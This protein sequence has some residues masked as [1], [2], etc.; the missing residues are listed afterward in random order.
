[1]K[2]LDKNKVSDFAFIS[3]IREAS[4]SPKPGLV[5][6]YNSG[7]HRDMDFNTFIKSSFAIKNYFG[8][9]FSLGYEKDLKEEDRLLKLREL[10]KNCEDDMYKATNNVNT[11]KG[12]IF[13]LGLLSF[14][15]GILE[16]EN[17]NYNI[18]KIIEK[19]ESICSGISS[20]LKV[21][22]PKTYGEKLYSK[23]GFKG[24]RGE[25]EEGFKKANTI[26]IKNFKRCRENL[27]INDSLVEILF[28]FMT[29][30]EDSN[31]LGRGGIKDL[32]YVKNSAIKVKKLGAM[33]TEKGREYIFK[34]NDEFVKKNISPGGSADYLT[35]TYFLYLIDDYKNS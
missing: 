27:S 12:I 26:G 6:M 3:L 31:V 25:A 9:C 24:I 32:E 28:Y 18:D 15:A 30:V 16:N 21:K 17:K 13:S 2:I 5:D 33:H 35:L 29:E 34:L 8:D 11:H 14:V 19:V 7:S 1:M 10:G 23:Y 4:A 20:E 22:N